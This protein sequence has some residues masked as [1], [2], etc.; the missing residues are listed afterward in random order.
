[1]EF[2]IS[3]EDFIS[4]NNL[5]LADLTTLRPS[6]SLSLSES[7]PPAPFKNDFFKKYAGPDGRPSSSSELDSSDSSSSSPKNELSDSLSSPSSEEDNN[8]SSEVLNKSSSSEEESEVYPETKKRDI[9]QGG[10][11]LIVLIV[12]VVSIYFVEIKKIFIKR[13]FFD[14]E[15]IFL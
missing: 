1:M 7:S 10:N 3:I 15:K 2:I 13:K 9:I 4:S 11:V 12:V 8:S 6:S 5:S 14:G